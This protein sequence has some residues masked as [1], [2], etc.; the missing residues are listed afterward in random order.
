VLILLPKVP[1]T[2]RLDFTTHLSLTCAAF[3][4]QPSRI[5]SSIAL[6]SSV[7]A[8]AADHAVPRPTT[9]MM[10]TPYE[11]RGGGDGK[12]KKQ[13]MAELKLRR[14]TELNARLREDLDRRRIPVSEAAME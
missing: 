4:T 6:F 11:L 9:K 14:L 3:R 13:S 1:S 10:S 5:G 2:P 12:S 7:N 8:T